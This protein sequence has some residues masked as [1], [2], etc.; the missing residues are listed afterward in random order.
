[1]QVIAAARRCRSPLEGA[2]LLGLQT[3]DVRD[4][5]ILRE[6]SGVRKVQVVG[7]Q[8]C[9]RG[10]CARRRALR[11]GRLEWE[12]CGGCMMQRCWTERSIKKV[13][14]VQRD[15]NDMA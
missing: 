13:S 10:P 3:R 5:A 8:G 1:M 11:Q 12:L 7:R 2:A 15:R 6:E 4:L 14:V 9:I